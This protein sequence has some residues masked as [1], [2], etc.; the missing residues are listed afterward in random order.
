MSILITTRRQLTWAVSKVK[1][2]Q[3]DDFFDWQVSLL[4]DELGNNVI[5]N[6]WEK[7]IPEGWTKPIKVQSGEYDCLMIYRRRQMRTVQSGY[8]PS[9]DGLRLWMK[10]ASL[11]ILI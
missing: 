10:L 5:N 3:L 4:R 6:I 2:I 11:L 7:N 1:S 8:W 9:I